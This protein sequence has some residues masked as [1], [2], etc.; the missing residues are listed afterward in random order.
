MA[1][2]FREFECLLVEYGLKAGSVHGFP[3]EWT[4]NLTRRYR[5][6]DSFPER[7]GREEDNRGGQRCRPKQDRCAYEDSF[8]QNGF[9][10][11][12]MF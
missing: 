9:H 3:A 5:G 1:F 12:W 8:N 2:I 10:I 4:E 7:D 6:P 11:L